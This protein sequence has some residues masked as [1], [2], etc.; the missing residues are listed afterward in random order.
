MGPF[1]LLT[2]F[3]RLRSKLSPLNSSFSLSGLNLL[4]PLHGAG[5]IVETAHLVSAGKVVVGGLKRGQFVGELLVIGRQKLAHVN[6]LAHFAGQ[7]GKEF[8][9]APPGRF[10]IGRRPAAAIQQPVGAT[11]LLRSRQNQVVAQTGL[12]ACDGPQP[13]GHQKI[14]V[15]AV[16][17]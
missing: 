14:K 8:F 12:L 13:A 5:F 9:Q 16:R 1:V 3:C 4:Q 7:L 2:R 10:G 15:G 17:Q 11:A 6:R